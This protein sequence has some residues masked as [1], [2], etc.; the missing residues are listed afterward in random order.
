MYINTFEIPVL[1]NIFEDNYPIPLE[2][3]MQRHFLII[4]ETGS[5]KTVSII[6]PLLKAAIEYNNKDYKNSASVLVVDPKLSEL[7]KFIK[8]S[9][10]DDEDT[11]NRIIDFEEEYIFDFF[12]G[13]RDKSLEDK[14]EILITLSPSFNSNNFGS[15]NREW[16]KFASVFIRNIIQFD[17]SV[18]NITGKSLWKALEESK[19]ISKQELSISDDQPYF[20]NF[21]KFID[22]I[23]TIITSAGPN[24]EYYK[25]IKTISDLIPDDENKTDEVASNGN[26]EEPQENKADEIRRPHVRSNNN[27]ETSG[28]Q[29]GKT[30]YKNLKEKLRASM[31]NSTPNATKPPNISILDEQK[32]GNLR[33]SGF[34]INSKSLGKETYGSII[35]TLSPFVSDYSYSDLNKKIWLDPFNEYNEDKNNKKYLNLEEAILNHKI[36]IFSPT[37]KIS[38]IEGMLGTILKTKFFKFML[39]TYEAGKRNFPAFYISD[40]F[41][42]YITGDTITGEQNFLDICRAYKIS[43]I[44]ATQSY[45][46]LLNAVSNQLVNYGNAENVVDIITINCANRFFFR[47]QDPKLKNLIRSIV[48]EKPGYP[49]V[50]DVR[51]L[52]SLEVGQCYYTLA[53]GKWGIKKINLLQN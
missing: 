37:L 27:F 20:I 40:E 32:V 36:I 35:L 18:R 16:F 11:L 14:I 19:Y 10:K 7:K 53:N 43:C 13:D 30:E 22:Y 48:P 28:D 15:R 26:N 6:K 9:Y 2:N 39:S 29:K 12:E 34:L 46:S 8:E 41:H 42:K 51:P 49:H 4:G 33:G 17:E 23:S 1:K 24:R 21:K 44:L 38:K 3:V 47:S 25:I 5:G 31:A 52:A 45:Q 50:I